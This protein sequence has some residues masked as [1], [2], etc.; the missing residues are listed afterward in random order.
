MVAP[1]CPGPVAVFSGGGTGGHLY[2]ALALSDALSSLRPDVRMFFVGA[3][4]GVEARILP[5]R[6]EDHL[7]VPVRGFRRGKI[8]ENLSVLW[9]LLRS[10]VATGQLFSRLRP[11]IVVVTGGYAGGPAGLMA[12]VMGIPLALQEQNARPGFT[13][14]VLS[15]WSRQVH[16]AFPES[17][18]LLPRRARSR[19]RLSGNPVRTVSEVD[20]TGAR[21]RFRVDSEA[22][23]VLVVGGSQGARGINQAVLDMIGSVRRGDL[24]WPEDAVLLWATGPR[25]FQEVGEA[26]EAMGTPPWVRVVDYIDDMPQALAIATL[27]VSRAGAMATSEFL[28]W[29]IPSI[30]VPL[31]TAAADH[32]T[33]NAES[34]AASGCALHLPEKDLT[35]GSLHDHA[36]GLLLD[37]AAL[38][39]ME[40]AALG[41]GRPNASREIAEALESLLPPGPE[42]RIRAP[43][44]RAP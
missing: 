1:G 21:S 33:R 28:S 35:G 30:L 39:G 24:A 41:R 44:G 16:L 9:S 25:N 15:L 17:R 13:T 5:E 6:G 8:L 31:P 11:G 40:Q 20:E 12:G 10:L 14:R 18:D 36:S 22:R 37:P 38:E 23:V 7:L 3:L 29:G 19:T 42:G 34:L 43:E 26:L 2:P 32:Q 27:A 4:Q